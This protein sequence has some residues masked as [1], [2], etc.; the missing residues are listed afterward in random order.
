MPVELGDDQIGP[1]ESVVLTE[2]PLDGPLR[3][4]ERHPPDLDVARQRHMKL[5][6][7]IDDQALV[8]LFPRR[9]RCELDHIARKQ[10]E[11]LGRIGFETPGVDSLWGRKRRVISRN[12]R[13]GRV[14][15]PR[16]PG[17]ERNGQKECRVP[18]HTGG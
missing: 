15:I 8:D 13:R 18:T 14:T 2:S 16:A 12:G 4:G 9:D 17:Y 7:G 6:Q 1:S 11:R 10:H 3:F 5:P